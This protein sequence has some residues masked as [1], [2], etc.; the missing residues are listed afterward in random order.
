MWWLRLQRNIRDR[1]EAWIGHIEFGGFTAAAEA[2]ALRG[3][4]VHTHT[5]EALDA[6]DGEWNIL[7]ED[8]FDQA[9]R[10]CMEVDHAPCRTFTEAR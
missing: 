3:M 10:L 2:E 4:L 6:F 5:S 8:N 9:F 1:T 7:A